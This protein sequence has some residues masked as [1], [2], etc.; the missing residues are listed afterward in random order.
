ML[1]N[2]LQIQ[3]KLLQKKAIP[4]TAEATSELIGNE[5][6]N[7]ITKNSPLEQFRM[8]HKQKKNQY[9][10]QKKD[11]YLQKKRQQIIDGLRLI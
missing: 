2:L 5:I 7:K 9:K 11:I 10:Y 3:L 4:K 1:N 6:T 8:I